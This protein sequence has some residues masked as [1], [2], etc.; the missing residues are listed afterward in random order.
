M[1]FKLEQQASL[2]TNLMNSFVRNKNIPL[3]GRGV[4]ESSTVIKEQFESF[5]QLYGDLAVKFYL[6]GNI[7]DSDYLNNYNQLSY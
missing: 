5:S 3:L 4:D 6:I 7:L 2:T 1:I